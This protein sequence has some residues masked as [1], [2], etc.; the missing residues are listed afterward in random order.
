MSIQ[1]KHKIAVASLLCFGLVS[2]AVG[3]FYDNGTSFSASIT[4]A[5]EGHKT[6]K[7]FSADVKKPKALFDGKS[8]S[9]NY[10]LTIKNNT[11]TT[12]NITA[13]LTCMDNAG[14]A[15]F[16]LKPGTNELTYVQTLSS[17]QLTDLN[18]AKKTGTTFPCNFVFTDGIISQNLSFDLYKNRVS[19]DIK[20]VKK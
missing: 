13:N 19:V 4:S 14:T 15:T 8:A 3:L 5:Q 17:R 9:L 1:N 7:V 12:I 11:A 18:A 16:K 6:S 2:L 10:P 20:N